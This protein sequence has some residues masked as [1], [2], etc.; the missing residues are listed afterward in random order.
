MKPGAD[1]DSLRR[2]SSGLEVVSVLTS[3]LV[4]TWG[5]AALAPRLRWLMAVPLLLS[6][7]LMIHSLWWRGESVEQLGLTGRHFRAACRRLALPMSL[8]VLAL[9][10]VG[11]KSDMLLA[12][13]RLYRPLLPLIASGLAQQYLLQSFIHRR[14]SQTIG[15][16]DE[17]GHLRQSAA[18]VVLTAS[19]FALIH[20]PNLTLTILTFGAG[21]VWSWVYQRSPNIL[22][23]GISHGLMSL[24]VINTLPPWMLDSLSVGYKHFLY[25]KF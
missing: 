18:A 17:N 14:I 21:L 13:E 8:G 25:Q 22:A 11:M 9:V 5:L 23:I 19:C 12:T 6:A 1:Q 10:W 20:L 3:V 4:I 7:G 15:A 2:L 16:I 24:L